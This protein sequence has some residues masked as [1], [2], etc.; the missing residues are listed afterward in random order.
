MSLQ[1]H[2]ENKEREDI[3]LVWR[4]IEVM[5]KISDV[6]EVCLLTCLTTNRNNHET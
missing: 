1:I 6:T 4:R 5:V 2:W 3:T